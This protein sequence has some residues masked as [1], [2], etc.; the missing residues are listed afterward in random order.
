MRNYPS[1]QGLRP[2]PPASGG[3]ASEAEAAPTR[4]E[5]FSLS[6]LS[7]DISQVLKWTKFGLLKLIRGGVFSLDGSPSGCYARSPQGRQRQIKVRVTSN[8]R[9]PLTLISS[10]KG[11]AF[12]ISYHY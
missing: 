12:I 8:R 2:N 4:G 11:E 6:C 7:Q 9:I 1:L 3:Y 5:R 10:T